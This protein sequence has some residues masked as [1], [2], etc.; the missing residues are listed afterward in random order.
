M[1]DWTDQQQ[2]A[3]DL[4]GKN[5]LISAA[6]GSGKTAVL[7]E[8]IVRIL[9]EERIGIDDMLIVTF[10]NAAAG[11]MK[12]RIQKRLQEIRRENGM[13]EETDRDLADF[14]TK[15]I[16]N[17]PR[18]SIST[19][20]AFCIQVIRDHFSL[21]EIDP[22]SKLVNEAYGA[23]LQDDAID[24]AFE[25]KYDREEEDFQTLVAG[26]G[27]AK[28]D[29]A[30]RDLVKNIDHFIQAQP[31]PERWL[32]DQRDL[33]K[34]L[35][36]FDK[37]EDALSFLQDHPIGDVLVEGV[38]EQIR[39]AA[40]SIDRAWE[41]TEGNGYSFEEKLLVERD[42][43]RSLE[44]ASE[45]GPVELFD[46]LK[47]VSFERFSKKKSDE[48][49][50]DEWK[51]IQALRNEAK[52]IYNELTKKPVLDTQTFLS[53]MAYLSRI[54]DALIELVLSY[55][56]HYARLKRENTVLDF[57]DLEHLT[58]KILKNEAV[59]ESLRQKYA[60]IFY[61][62]YQDTNRVQETIVNAI[63]RKD[64]LFFVG[65]V[66]QS[67]YRFRL[68]D[69]TIFNE[70]YARYEQESLSE[71]IDLSNNFRSRKE[72]LDFCNLIF[73]EVMTTSYGEV[74]YQNPSHQLYSGRALTEKK[75]EEDRKREGEG[76]AK[77]SLQAKTQAAP[78]IELALIRKVKTER[79][80]VKDEEQGQEAP[81]MEETVLPLEIV[82]IDRI[83]GPEDEEEADLSSIELEAIY[84]AQK[85]RRLAA[86]EV[87]LKDIAILFRSVRGKAD[88]FEKTLASYGIPSYVDH[89]ASHYDKL[90][91]K[92]LLDYLKVVDNKKQDEA[93]LGAMSSAF[94]NFEN[95]E[96]ISIR[97]RYPQ[98]DFYLAA[99]SYAKQMQDELSEKLRRFYK[100]LADDVRRE[101]MT[102]L[103][104]FIWYVAESSG[105]NTYISGLGDSAQ[106]LHNIKSF[107]QKAQE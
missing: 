86:E 8:R 74:D 104:D 39:E 6:A 63:C 85:I 55:R 66:K 42:R 99:E 47:P 100:R 33:Y 83:A 36:S 2:Q 4:R 106:R 18:A 77:T 61:D 37:L 43:I 10:T 60:Y 84:T 30:L 62:E 76:K 16:Q 23:I 58:L 22:G 26:Y 91:I 25:E 102:A 72:I 57:S 64:N 52:E 97:E 92:C 46:L 27:E 48:L 11:E 34:K 19:V 65:D 75:N 73:K 87:E 67:I 7:V 103:P 54:V 31:E 40:E 94:G 96:L 20:H 9:V 78:S 79:K 17:V 44:E 80:P 89:S 50:D 21:A 90:E 3:I 49:E 41:L 82:S 29:R 12:Q 51:Q 14:L 24:L 93:L 53:D 95:E 32:A 69:P 98:G 107:V 88:I 13:R 15:Q 38:R 70:K 56:K 35:S 81:V 28:G 59:R 5:L 68:A 105:F 101:K 71:K 1:R 45:K